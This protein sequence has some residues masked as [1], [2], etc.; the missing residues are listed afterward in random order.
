MSKPKTATQKNGVVVVHAEGLSLFNYFIQKSIFLNSENQISRDP[1][2]SL[3]DLNLICKNH[4]IP[5]LGLLS[6]LDS[7]ATIALTAG[8]L[9]Y[10][11][12]NMVVAESEFNKLSDSIKELWSNS[13][14]EAQRD[15]I[16]NI[17]QLEEWRSMPLDLLKDVIAFDPYKILGA[18][19][20][21]QYKY[22]LNLILLPSA[23]LAY[24]FPKTDSA[25]TFIAIGKITFSEPVILSLINLCKY[26]LAWNSGDGNFSLGMPYGD[27][28]DRVRV[29]P[30]TESQIMLFSSL[31]E[32]L[33]NLYGSGYR[34]KYRAMLEADE[35][36]DLVSACSRVLP[37]LHQLQ[38][39]IVPAL[40][41]HF[42]R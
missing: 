10:I 13:W 24:R 5:N 37:V 14:K 1:I 29:A 42:V 4:L 23:A 40:Q 33:N 32:K 22:Q 16:K 8:M 36:N 3:K 30:L 39:V 20:V 26:I 6:A 15:I 9:S 21:D 12:K 31:K 25:G 35:Y 34:F 19:D 11:T 27:R 2:S 38:A 28:I 41:L 7:K 17:A 18:K